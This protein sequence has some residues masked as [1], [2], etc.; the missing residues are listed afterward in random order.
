MR[1][2]LNALALILMFATLFVALR[3]TAPHDERRA[4]QRAAG[5]LRQRV[6]RAQLEGAPAVVDA[7]GRV[8]PIGERERVVAVSTSATPAAWALLDPE[9]IVGVAAWSRNNG[10]DGWRYGGVATIESAN[11]V[12]SILSLRPD[13]VLY[14]SLGNEAA[15]QRLVERGVAVFDLGQMTGVDAYL[16]QM[17][18]LGVLLEREERAVDYILRLEAMEQGLACEGVDRVA[19]AYIS[20]YGTRYYG[21]ARGTTFHDV[22]RMA[23]LDDAAADYEGWPEYTTEEL[24][25]LNPPYVLTAEGMGA[26]LCSRPELRT[27]QACANPG[28][29]IVELDGELLNDAAEGMFVAAA[30]LRD[31]VY[32]EDCASR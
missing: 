8:V 16:H 12:E 13:L 9:R 5:E 25:A 4:G 10:W 6:H 11:D 2:G 18:T 14:N 27:L 24:I 15:I 21:G 28:Q 3:A 31:A 26:Q 22:L 30:L 19:G 32:G 29:R 20:V 1:Q 17:A 7:S 23:G